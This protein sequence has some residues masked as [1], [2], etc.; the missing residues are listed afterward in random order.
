M[1]IRTQVPHFLVDYWLRCIFGE[2]SGSQALCG[3]PPLPSHSTMSSA[4]PQSEI[5]NSA[6]SCLE[7]QAPPQ[8]WVPLQDFR[9]SPPRGKQSSVVVVGAAFR[10]TGSPCLVMW[11]WGESDWATNVEPGPL[12]AVSWVST[13]SR[14]KLR[15]RHVPRRGGSLGRLGVLSAF[16]FVAIFSV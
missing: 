9:I 3:A 11:Q 5:N 7:T 14:R 13:V 15:V 1:R 8:T 16:W 2:H 10:S 6:G 12:S 4:H